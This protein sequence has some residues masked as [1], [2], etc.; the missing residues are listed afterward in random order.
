MKKFQYHEP[1]TIAEACSLLSE[2]GDSARLLAGGTDL[3]VRMKKGLLA[4]EHVIDLKL[5]QELNYIQET[6]AGYTFGALTHLASIV[7]HTGLKE[8]IPV[9]ASSAATIGSSQIRNLATL[10][11]NLCNAAPSADMAPGLLVLAA[12]VK[13]VGPHGS[14]NS[15]LEDFF[16]GPGEVDL[17][18]GELLTEVT[19]PYPAVGC[20][21]LYLKHGPRKAM[22]CAVVGVAAALVLEE[23]TR[24]CKSARIALGAVAPTPVRMREVENH[25]EGKRLAEISHPGLAR[26]VQMGIE[27]I[28]DVRGSAAYRQEV[29]AVLTLRAVNSLMNGKER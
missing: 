11:G 4:P 3:I 20:R 18:R 29:A 27:P 9:L 22:D 16:C 28:S 19:V 13:I 2:L 1:K 6:E 14:R 23:S 5:L 24:C 7:E 10:G 15:T 25:L 8:R 26:L 12:T 17:A 21:S